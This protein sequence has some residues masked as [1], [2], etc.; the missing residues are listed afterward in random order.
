MK[1]LIVICIAAIMM[2]GCVSNSRSA[3]YHKAKQKSMEDFH[4]NNYG[5]CN[6]YK[7]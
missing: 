6:R 7:H 3:N 4:K 5:K 1:K 2:V